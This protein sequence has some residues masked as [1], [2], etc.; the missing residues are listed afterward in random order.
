MENI[1]ILGFVGLLAL[2]LFD[3]KGGYLGVRRALLKQGPSSIPLVTLPIYLLIYG[4]NPD[5]FVISRVVDAV[6]IITLHLALHFFIPMLVYKL[7][8]D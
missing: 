4:L 6:L 7:K 5:F 8:H 1:H 2:I 3:L